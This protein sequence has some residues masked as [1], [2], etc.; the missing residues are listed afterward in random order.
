[1]DL[2]H[3][4][5]TFLRLLECFSAAQFL[6][7]TIS[8]DKRFGCLFS[9]SHKNK[10][11]WNYDFELLDDAIHDMNKTRYIDFHTYTE[12]ISEFILAE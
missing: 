3:N 12:A 11:L 8:K 7:L 4:V 9:D 5:G 10:I 6:Y 1:M 2:T